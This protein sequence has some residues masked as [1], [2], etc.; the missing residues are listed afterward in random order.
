MTATG[1]YLEGVGDMRENA[2]EDAAG[3]F[4]GTGYPRSIN[5]P[6]IVDRSDAAEALLRF[7][8]SNADANDHDANDYLV[9]EFCRR[10]RDSRAVAAPIPVPM[11]PLVECD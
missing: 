3:C 1:R 2:Y 8:L 7:F 11:V 6:V 10:S 5:D 4:E 9:E